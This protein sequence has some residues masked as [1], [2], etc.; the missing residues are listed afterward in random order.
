MSA[1]HHVSK[2]FPALKAKTCE[3][4]RKWKRRKRGIRGRRK[5]RIKRELGGEKGNNNF[6]LEKSTSDI[7]KVLEPRNN[8]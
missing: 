2:P 8:I 6:Y 4:Q 7:R 1:Q 3:S 5:R